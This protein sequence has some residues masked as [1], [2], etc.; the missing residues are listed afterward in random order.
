M[1][2]RVFITILLVAA[3]T[4]TPSVAGAVAADSAAPQ[5]TRTL[6]AFLAAWRASAKSRDS[7]ASL[8]GE[9]RGASREYLEETISQREQEVHKAVLGAADWITEETEKGHAVTQP[10]QSA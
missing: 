3:P 4:V 10:P 1:V 2:S 6:E 5:P 7:L 8:A 9:A